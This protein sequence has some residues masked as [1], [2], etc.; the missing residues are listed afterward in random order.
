MNTVR[1]YPEDVKERAVRPGFSHP[2][3]E[4][5]TRYLGVYPTPGDRH[6]K[7]WTSLLARSPKARAV[8]HSG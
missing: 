3:A 4:R 7:P 5:E 6:G 1:R 2:P 8:T